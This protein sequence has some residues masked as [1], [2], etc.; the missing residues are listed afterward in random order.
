MTGTPERL[1][2]PRTA[3][4]A[5]TRAVAVPPGGVMA[6]QAA[7]GNRAVQRHIEQQKA[8]LDEAT[9]Q[10]RADH[11]VLTNAFGDSNRGWIRI[12]TGGQERKIP[13]ESLGGHHAEGLLLK[14]AAEIITPQ[15]LGNH[16]D[17]Q[18]FARVLDMYTER[19]P[20]APGHKYG[21]LRSR[22]FGTAD[23]CHSML[24]AA[25][26]AQTPVYYSVPDGDRDQWQKLRL[27]GT[28]RLAEE[29]VAGLRRGSVQFNGPIRAAHEARHGTPGRDYR[30]EYRYWST[31]T[32]RLEGVYAARTGKRP[33]DL[34]QDPLWTTR[35]P[36]R[37]G[38]LEWIE[39]G[40][41]SG[42]DV[43]LERI[44]KIRCDVLAAIE[45]LP[46]PA[47][48]YVDAGTSATRGRRGVSN[49]PAHPSGDAL[50]DTEEPES[51]PD[52]TPPVPTRGA[53]T[54]SPVA[55]VGGHGGTAV[56]AIS[57][58]PDALGGAAGGV[59]REEE[60]DDAEATASTPDE[61]ASQWRGSGVAVFGPGG[62]QEEDE[63]PEG[64][65]DPDLVPN[66]VSVD[67]PGYLPD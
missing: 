64:R 20:C 34:H 22:T 54:P 11:S 55:G 5:R 44:D 15:A 4:A 33:R 50:S 39:V 43:M 38:P 35:T 12:M 6:L 61:A 24:Q 47:P 10:A 36:G 41:E 2:E 1:P 30:R 23:D 63:E 58:P 40:E 21:N 62:V 32:S 9:Y 56:D 25:L 66:A 27:A 17:D 8:G 53:I 26:H 18:R 28:N 29:V 37:Y 42:S 31:V 48:V 65:H 3:V 51:S 52:P 45:S 60:E 7:A 13:A 57:S 67:D 49:S 14:K 46:T 59:E 16:P 19:R